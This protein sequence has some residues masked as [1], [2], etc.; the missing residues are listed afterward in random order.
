MILDQLGL[1]LNYLAHIDEKW[2]GLF[3]VEFGEDDEIITTL[4]DVQKI[5][6]DL[7][8]SIEEGE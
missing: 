4:G 7:Y 6:S 3:N 2:P 1:A 8:D 5:I